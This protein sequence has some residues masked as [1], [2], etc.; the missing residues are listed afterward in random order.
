[1]SAI[2]R[3]ALFLA[4][5]PASAVC[6]Q[7]LWLSQPAS[8]RRGGFITVLALLSPGV[9][10]IRRRNWLAYGSLAARLSACESNSGAG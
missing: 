6:K 10:A 8:K 5:Q 7:A 4:G 9:M 2:W 1:V 3:P